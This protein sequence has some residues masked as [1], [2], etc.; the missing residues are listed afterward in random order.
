MPTHRVSRAAFVDVIAKVNDEIGRA[1]R[2]VAIGAVIALLVLLA[3]RKRKAQLLHRV[4]YLG[5][6]RGPPD[7]AGRRAAMKPIEV[8]PRRF[9][10]PYFHMHRMAERRLC[11]GL[12]ARGAGGAGFFRVNRR[13]R[14]P[15]SID[16]A[17]IFRI[18]WLALAIDHKPALPGE[19]DRG[20]AHMVQPIAPRQIFLS[21]RF[22]VSARRICGADGFH[23]TNFRAKFQNGVLNGGALLRLVFDLCVF[24]FFRHQLQIN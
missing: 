6:G 10:P 2:H 3:G 21:A 11:I 19:P 14:K 15:Q 9:K 20:R 4:A 23:R 5:R 7:N 8:R 24:W 22:C 17:E 18:G 12:A 1:R 13:A 16:A